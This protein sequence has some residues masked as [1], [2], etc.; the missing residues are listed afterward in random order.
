MSDEVKIGCIIGFVVTVFILSVS[1][2][3]YHGS[4]LKYECIEKVEEVKND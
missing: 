3:V 2:N 4:T 1:V